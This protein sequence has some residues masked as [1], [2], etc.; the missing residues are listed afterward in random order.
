MVFEKKVAVPKE[1]ALLTKAAALTGNTTKAQTLQVVK[2]ALSLT[3][4]KY[5]QQLDSR[6]KVIER[7]Q[8][9]LIA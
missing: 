8:E 2:E 7:Q 4:E 1:R 3:E 6:D 9:M 5:R